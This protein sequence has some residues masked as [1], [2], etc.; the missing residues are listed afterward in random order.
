[1]WLTEIPALMGKAFGKVRLTPSNS[2]GSSP[3]KAKWQDIRK[4]VSDFKAAQPDGREDELPDIEGPMGAGCDEYGIEDER[5]ERSKIAEQA[6]DDKRNDQFTNGI[7]KESVAVIQH[8]IQLYPHSITGV[9]LMTERDLISGAG[10]KRECCEISGFDSTSAGGYVLDPPPVKKA[11]KSSLILDLTRTAAAHHEEVMNFQRSHFEYEKES[12][13]SDVARHS[14]RDARE[15]D[16]RER[17]DARDQKRYINEQNRLASAQ[18]D[19]KDINNVF[20]G[21]LTS[22][23]AK[24]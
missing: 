9:G 19:A 16:Y 23:V 7:D 11:S 6:R 22:I 2:L 15:V 10:R 5:M 17:L 13:Q 21:F 8:Y 24:L 3:Y 12:R 4:R 1:M 18:Q 20:A 14:L